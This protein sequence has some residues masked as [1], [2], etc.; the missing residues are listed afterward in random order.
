MRRLVAV[1]LA[2]CLA[3]GSLAASALAEPWAG[4]GAAQIA[5]ADWV[6]MTSRNEGVFFDAYVERGVGLNGPYA[7]AFVARGHCVRTG[8]RD[9]EI[10]F[11]SGVAHARR[12][13]DREFQMD[14][15]LRT[16]ALRVKDHQWVHRVRW[17]GKGD[18]DAWYQTGAFAGAW[19]G[20][21]G[22]WVGVDRWAPAHGRLYGRSLRPKGFHFALLEG[23]AGAFAL[24][25]AG[26]RMWH[27]GAG[28]LHLSRT[29]RIE[30]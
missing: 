21:S 20:A 17:K 18:P 9:I 10:I 24:A 16:A 15:L 2:S 13:S 11:C 14:P 25:A 12:V 29:I 28:R 7:L 19:G 8:D 6:R 1:V 22:A 3:L 26:V 5:Y 27:D 30:H 4:G 23:S